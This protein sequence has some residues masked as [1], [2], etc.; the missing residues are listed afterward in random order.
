MMCV[1]DMLWV[2]T[3]LKSRR[4]STLVAYRNLD[5]KKQSFHKTSSFAGPTA[6]MRLTRYG[7]YLST[8]F[9]RE[10][11]IIRWLLTSN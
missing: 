11:E 5:L 2:R 4:M 6:Q 1:C 9:W 3:G 8:L 7:K 10:D